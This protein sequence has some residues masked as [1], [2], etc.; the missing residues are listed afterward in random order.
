MFASL[1][2]INSNIFCT[3]VK[4]LQKL[5]P[6]SDKSLD[7]FTNNIRSILN[8]FELKSLLVVNS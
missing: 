5:Y 3:R 8:V 2:H 6:L 7:I 1:F 4:R